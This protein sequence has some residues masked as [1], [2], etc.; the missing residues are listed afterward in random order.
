[1]L[2]QGYNQTPQRRRIF[3][4]ELY[5]QL[6]ALLRCDFLSDASDIWS[7]LKDTLFISSVG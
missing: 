5:R 7:L 1:L 4:T 6:P 3:K 2:F